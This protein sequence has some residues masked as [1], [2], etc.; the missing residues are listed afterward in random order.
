MKSDRGP[1]VVEAAQY[2][3]AF[4]DELVVVK[5]G[6]ELLDGGPVLERILPQ[7]VVLYQCGLR[8]VIVHGGGKQVDE[9][10]AARG[11]APVKHGGR[12][13]T[14]PEALEVLVDVVGGSLNRAIVDRLRRDGVLAKGF[15]EGVTAAVRCVRRPA[16]IIGGVAVDWGEVGDVVS[17]DT[18]PLL[19]EAE[20]TWVVPV[21]PSLGTGP[22]GELLNVNADT[23]ASRVGVAL[24]SAKLLLLTAVAGVMED[25]NSAGPISELDAARVRDLIGKGIVV[26]GMQAKLEEALRAL[27]GGVPRVHII[28]GR[29]PATLLREIFTDEGCGTLI[30]PDLDAEG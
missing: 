13:V 18:T 11:I 28:S 5:L 17:I 3:E 6:G 4:R 12:R 19:D 24:S 27:E 8:P 9:A 16:S 30:V 1:G 21:L 10:C 2:I 29:E 15:E 26:G 23:V 22:D 7:V 14:T 20:G 25:P